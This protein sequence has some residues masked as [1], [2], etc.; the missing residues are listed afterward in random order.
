MALS[1]L[2]TLIR[3]VLKKLVKFHGRVEKID[4]KKLR[5]Y[6]SIKDHGQTYV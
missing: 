5:K 4:N 3:E 2:T 1:K 6:D